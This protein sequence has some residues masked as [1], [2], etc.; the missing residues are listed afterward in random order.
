MPK[1]RTKRTAAVTKTPWWLT[2][3]EVCAHCGQVYAYELEF[4]CPDCDEACCTHCKVAHPEGRF[5][6]VT[7]VTDCQ[8]HA[9]G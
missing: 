1:A 7:C 2:G 8:E 5:V 9:H 6:C 3:E 4:R